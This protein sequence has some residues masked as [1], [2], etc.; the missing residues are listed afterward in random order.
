[1][2]IIECGWFDE[3]NHKFLVPVLTFLSCD[4]DT[5]VTENMKR[6]TQVVYIPEQ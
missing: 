4:A 6:K 3:I 2:Y 1:L 5:G